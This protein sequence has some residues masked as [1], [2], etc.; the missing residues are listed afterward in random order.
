MHVVGASVRDSAAYVLWSLART[1]PASSI[2]ATD[3]QKLAEHL[4]CTACLDREVSVRRAASAAWQESVGRWVS[5]SS[6]FLPKLER[7]LTPL[8]L[9]GIFSH[10][11][12]ILRATDFYTVSVR[13]RAY[14]LGAVEVA[15]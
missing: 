12:S 11:I 15:S 7:A 8:S 3:A 1:M 4:L 9:Q 5:S 14:L 6:L 13:Y 2:D 10:G